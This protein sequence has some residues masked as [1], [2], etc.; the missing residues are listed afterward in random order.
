MKTSLFY[1]VCFF[2]LF[3]FLF[4]VTVS[5]AKE[6]P[7]IR[8]LGISVGILPTG[9]W[10]AI[11]DV[12]GVKVGHATLIKGDSFR[13]GVTVI[14]PHDGNLFREKVT[15]A[16]YV[17]N[18][19]GKLLGKIQVDELGEIETPVALTSTLNV[20]R[21]AD[22]L[23]DYMLSLPGN[24]DVR[25][26]NPVVGETND[27]RLNDIQKRAVGK[28]QVFAA[29]R[30]AKSGPVD[31]G[32][33]G[34]GTGTVCFGFKGGIGTSSRK[35]PRELGGFTV[36]VLV[37]TNFGGVLQ[38]NGV[39]VGQK[40]GKY[41]YKRFLNKKDDGSCAIVVATDAP[42][43]ARNLKRLAKRTLLGLARTGGYMSNG[44]GDYVIAF[45]TFAGNRV[46]SAG[47]EKKRKKTDV[48][49]NAMSPL[50][51][52]AVEATEEAIY[53]SLFQAKTMT[54]FKGRTVEE[55]PLNEVIP[56][57]KEK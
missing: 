9:K 47:H 56:W 12:P 34:A 8:E 2:I 23:I 5:V 19:F 22:A 18:G 28:E 3:V 38:I 49:N 52:A 15:G 50:F 54:G 48:D 42:L 32:N 40:L 33:V 35:L 43:S 10:N 55:L 46:S 14:L 30:D 57:L 27:G 29:L 51:L 44:S 11:T 41:P 1:P 36:G 53:N 45:S 4:T 39:P 20:F 21:V 6:K 13:T 25:S 24:E 7:R 31:E 37:Q 26:I 17:G 16:I